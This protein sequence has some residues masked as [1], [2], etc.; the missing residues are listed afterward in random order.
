M[1]CRTRSGRPVRGRAG[2]RG[3][4][5]TVCAAAALRPAHPSA[6]A[7]RAVDGL[8]TQ[9]RHAAGPPLDRP[10]GPEPALRG[11]RGA[12]IG[13]RGRRRAMARPC[14]GGGAGVRRAAPAGGVG[15]ARLR[16][17]RLRRRARAGRSAGADDRR[18]ERA[19]RADAPAHGDRRTA[20]RAGA[21]SDRRRDA[22]EP[23]G[24]ARA[25][26]R[27]HAGRARRWLR[28]A[29]RDSV[30]RAHRRH[31]PAPSRS[32]PARHATAAADRGRGAV[33]GVGADP[34]RG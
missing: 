13:L 22:R 23:A 5:P 10:L 33:R 21:R 19:R 14:F 17:T 1:S 32:A 30:V 3:P 20:G 9:R 24:A 31:L 12:A 34:A 2:V 11:G 7:E 15:R 25:A 26:A 8:R 27:S 6:P 29:R 18:A 28:V 16:G 4:A